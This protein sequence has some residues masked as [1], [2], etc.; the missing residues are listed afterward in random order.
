MLWPQK[1]E[2]KGMRRSVTDKPLVD[3]TEL[4][5]RYDFKLVWTTG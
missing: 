5:D 1:A 2:L 3:Q 4:T